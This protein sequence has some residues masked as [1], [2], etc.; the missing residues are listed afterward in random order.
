MRGINVARTLPITQ[1]LPRTAPTSIMLPSPT[2]AASTMAFDST[3]TFLPRRV[4]SLLI[5]ALLLAE[6]M[7]LRLLSASSSGPMPTPILARS[8]TMTPS[9]STTGASALL[10]RLCGWS[11]V[12]G[13]R[14]IGCVPVI[15][16]CWAMRAEG[17][18]A[19]DE[20]LGSID[21]RLGAVE[22]RRSGPGRAGAGCEAMATSNVVVQWTAWERCGRRARGSRVCMDSNVSSTPTHVT[23]T[24]QL[25][26]DYRGN[27]IHVHHAITCSL[28]WRSRSR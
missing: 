21:V 14:V 8:H 19:I 28:A 9:P 26:H 13:P 11:T 15:C 6:A 4:P 3:T 1:P 20:G 24:S 25:I 2:S 17:S 7:E 12:F 10:I 23:P 16:A 22:D 18:R 27:K 5:E